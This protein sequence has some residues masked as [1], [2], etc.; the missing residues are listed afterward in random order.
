MASISLCS[1]NITVEDVT[2]SIDIASGNVTSVTSLGPLGSHVTSLQQFPDNV[3][4]DPLDGRAYNGMFFALSSP[5][6]FQQQRQNAIQLSLP[7][8]VFQAAQNAPEGLTDAFQNNK[9]ANLSSTVYVSSFVLRSCSWAANT[10]LLCRR[11]T[12]L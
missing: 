11:R 8:A 6:P 9:F 5:D 1:P 3:T 2:A 4:G 10:R 12:W 7:A